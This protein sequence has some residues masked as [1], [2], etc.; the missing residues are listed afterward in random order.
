[1]NLDAIEALLAAVR[2]AIGP[3]KKIYFGT[4]P[5]EVRPEHVTRES[6]GVLKRWV[7]N[8]SLVI[9][10]QSGSD[11][12][13]SAMRRGHDVAAVERAVR[14]AIGAG[15]RPDVDFLVG[16]PG[17]TREDRAL[18]L[19]FAERLVA[20]GARIHSHAFMPLP[21]TPLQARAPEPIEP[22]IVRAMERLESRGAMYGQWRRQIVS[23]AD[24]VR[25]RISPA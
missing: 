4:F 5:S 24:L 16:T 11:R 8:K 19:G 2:R 14:L 1:V 15:F 3:G 9:G 21:G 18:S 20:M 17:E 25:R 7:D 13:L 22:E 10:G 12:V 23:A 6:L